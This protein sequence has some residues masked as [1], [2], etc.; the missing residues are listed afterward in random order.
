MPMRRIEFYAKDNVEIHTIARWSRTRPLS[1]TLTDN[2]ATSRVTST[3]GVILNGAH[4][5]SNQ[6]FMWCGALYEPW[7]SAHQ[8][9]CNGMI[10]YQQ[11]YN[12]REKS[13]LIGK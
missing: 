5:I 6:V 9:T 7:I 10:K 3:A 1:V 11:K 12:S 13:N 4:G 2:G 8:R